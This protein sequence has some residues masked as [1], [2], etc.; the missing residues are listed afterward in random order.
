MAHEVRVCACVGVGGAG[1]GRAHTCSG[2]A[3][4]PPPPLKRP[5][6]LSLSVLLCSTPR[7]WRTATS[8]EPHRAW[9]AGG[10]AQRNAAPSTRALRTPRPPRAPLPNPL[11]LDAPHTPTHPVLARFILAC[12][13]PPPLPTT[14]W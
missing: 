10:A 8:R 13:L 1:G 4:R 11:H 7:R 9:L 2:G 5:H 12:Q 6:P 14:T 3:P